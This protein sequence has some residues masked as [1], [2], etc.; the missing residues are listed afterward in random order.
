MMQ[1][2]QDLVY[3][4][5]HPSACVLDLY[6]PEKQPCPV[7]IYFH[8]GGLVGGSHHSPVMQALAQEHGIA[9]ASAQYRMYPEARYPQFI[10]DA[11][12]AAKFVKNYGQLRGCF[13][14]YIIGGSSAGA[15]L[16]MML[17]FDRRYLAAQGL[18]PEHFDG[19]VFN[20]GQPTAH[21]EVLKRRGE[22]ERACIV[23]DTAPL[24]HVRG[25]QPGRP[26]FFIYADND[27]PCR[28]EQNLLLMRTLEHC[29]YD[30]ALISGKE[31]CGYRHCEYDSAKDEHSKYIFA[32][33]LANFIKKAIKSS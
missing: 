8:G 14:R 19:Y 3:N 9:V 10:Q 13:D 24:Y 32:E 5:K 25:A 17:A 26:L 2:I 16:S 12:A 31:M 15:Y 20:A 27:M 18:Q 22:D 23:D 30:P 33:M 28:K 11:A 1:I 29:G 4:P 6:L 21:Y 7:L